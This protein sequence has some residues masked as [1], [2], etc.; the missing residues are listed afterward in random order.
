VLRA[1]LP[2]LAGWTARRRQL[3]AQYRA[4]LPD[5]LA[6]IH[7]RDPGHV[8]HLFPVRLRA[9]DELSAHLAQKGIGTLIHYPVP[10]SAQQAFAVYEPL[11][12]PVASAAAS[13]LLSLP[14]HP[15]LT[16]A[17]VARV[18]HDVSEFVK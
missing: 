3:A 12:C 13:E 9:R 5:S 7:E 14:L 6:T 16:D 4:Q 11:P 15:R 18:V 1:R 10:L 8:Y 17:D 2:L